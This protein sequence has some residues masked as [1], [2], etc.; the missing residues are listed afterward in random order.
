[1]ILRVRRRWA[2]RSPLGRRFVLLVCLLFALA[3]PS[4]ALGATNYR[5]INGYAG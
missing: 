5:Y 1:M 4:L 2:A 3:V